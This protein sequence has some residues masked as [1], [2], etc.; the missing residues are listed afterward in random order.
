MPHPT[1]WAPPCPPARR[2]RRRPTTRPHQLQALSRC[3]GSRRSG[4]N[5]ASSSATAVASARTSATNSG[6]PSRAASA[7]ATAVRSGS[8]TCSSSRRVVG[9]GYSLAGRGGAAE[10]RRA[11]MLPPSRPHTA[12]VRT[13]V[14]VAV[15]PVPGWWDR[16]AVLLRSS[17]TVS[18]PRTAIT[19]TGQA[20]ELG[21]G[22][23]GCQCG[24]QPLTLPPVHP[25][26][27]APRPCR[28]LAAADGDDDGAIH[29][30]DVNRACRAAFVGVVARWSSWCRVVVGEVPGC[31]R[32]GGAGLRTC[33][34]AA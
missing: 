2:E 15:Q 28:L 12:D 23:Q 11:G 32:Y 26:G 30:D 5:G 9:G 7:R 1:G 22:R 20:G 4:V 34:D 13:N 27:R 3:I 10:R 21:V 31:R 24:G 25:R 16:S 17:G 14:R 29:G 6:P 19:R 8:G 18:S 33:E